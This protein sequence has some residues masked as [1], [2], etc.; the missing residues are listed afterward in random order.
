[1]PDPGGLNSFSADAVR[2]AGRASSYWSTIKPKFGPQVKFIGSKV[3]L[4]SI[5]GK[6]LQ[7][8]DFAQTPEPGTSS[9]NTLPHEVSE[10][11]TLKTLGTGRSDRGR[12]FL[13]PMSSSA[14]TE[15]GR[16]RLDWLA[17]VATASAT[18][19]ADFAAPPINA[20]LY[21]RK[22][23]SLAPLNGLTFGDVFDA[24]RRRRDALVEIRE[25]RSI[26]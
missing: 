16:I 14:L 13:P 12:F 17:D 8:V 2:L 23:D 26:V 6:I 15:F 7:G 10:V 24:Q 19:L 18:L 22:N 4:L 1:M 20:V 21:S 9:G 3:E 11:V 25:T 5:L